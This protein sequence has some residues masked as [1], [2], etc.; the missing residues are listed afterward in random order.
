MAPGES[1]LA[2]LLA[3]LVVSARPD[4]YA[5]CVLT[6]EPPPLGDG[7]EMILR[8]T[9]AVTV[10]ATVEVA[11][12]HGWQFEFEAAWLTVEVHSAL[13]AVGLTAAF[14][15]ALAEANLPCNV[16]AGYYHDHVLVPFERAGE[17]IEQLEILRNSSNDL[18]P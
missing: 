17:A 7:V 11:M 2:V 10:I 13:S 15:T 12:R 16:L 9:E 4:R 14:S 1:N 8:E 6:G 5:V 3:N 18:A